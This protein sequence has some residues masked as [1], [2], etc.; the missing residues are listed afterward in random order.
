MKR[1][2]VVRFGRSVDQREAERIVFAIDLPDSFTVDLP[3]GRTYNAQGPSM[4]RWLAA[5]KITLF[6]RQHYRLA[7]P[8]RHKKIQPL[9]DDFLGRGGP[10]YDQNDPAVKAICRRILDAVKERQNV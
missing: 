1:Y 6:H 9:I 3:D 4:A 8:C 5:D 10:I 2:Y 7:A